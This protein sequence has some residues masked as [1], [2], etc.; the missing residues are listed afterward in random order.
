MYIY[1]TL[2]NIYGLGIIVL[3]VIVPQPYSLAFVLNR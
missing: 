1:L 2:F 3:H